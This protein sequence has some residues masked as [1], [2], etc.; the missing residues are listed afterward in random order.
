MPKF[1]RNDL[2][3][4]IVIFNCLTPRI[5]AL[6]LVIAGNLHYFCKASP[7]AFMTL[8]LFWIVIWG[9][10][11]NL[12]YSSDLARHQKPFDFSA[13]WPTINKEGDAT[14]IQ[15]LRL[16]LSSFIFFGFGILCLIA[17]KADTHNQYVISNCVS[18]DGN[19]ESLDPQRCEEFEKEYKQEGIRREQG[20][21]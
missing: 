21:V 5:C 7:L 20:D 16:I 4:T 1:P 10:Q 2:R 8:S 19:T 14:A 6:Y 12:W 15:Y 17:G 11:F 13:H 18:R 3:C 9:L